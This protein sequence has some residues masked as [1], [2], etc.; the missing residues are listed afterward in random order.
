MNDNPTRRGDNMW[1][2]YVLKTEITGAGPVTEGKSKQH[3][4]QEQEFDW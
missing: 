4:L 2:M 3:Q 1:G